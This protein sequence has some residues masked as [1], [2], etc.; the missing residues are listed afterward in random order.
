MLWCFDVNPSGQNLR[1]HSQFHHRIARS[2]S[3]TRIEPRAAT[4]H[5][6]A[7]MGSGRAQSTRS[8]LLGRHFIRRRARD[9][10][11]LASAVTSGTRV[12]QGAFL[13]SWV[14]R[15]ELE[16]ASARDA[17]TAPHGARRRMIR[18]NRRRSIDSR[19]SRQ[20]TSSGGCTAV[21]PRPPFIRMRM[22]RHIR[23]SHS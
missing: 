16:R 9:V 8:P 2:C 10:Q 6:A 19:T 11:G 18:R 13:S 4:Y 17:P 7:R 21:G 1:S 22:H 5:L 15:G 20:P 12:W 14:S 3:T 23:S